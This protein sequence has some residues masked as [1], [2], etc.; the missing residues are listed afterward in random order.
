MGQESA[1]YFAD[2]APAREAAV[3]AAL[4]EGGAEERGRDDARITLCLRDPNR[5]WID[6]LVH[7]LAGLWLEIRIALTNDEW[8]IRGPLEQA[9]VTLGSGAVLA[10]E[11]GRELGTLGDDGWSLALEEDYGARRQQ[12]IA[13]MGDFNAPLPAEH[14]YLYVH[15]TRRRRDADRELALRREREINRIEQMWDPPR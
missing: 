5:Y 11:D 13:R 15:Q 6:L 2:L 8:S 14:V 1:S 10:D 3:V 12:F 4:L 9:F 7:R